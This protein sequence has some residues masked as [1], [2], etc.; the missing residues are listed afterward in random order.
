MPKAA[1]R[2][3][4]RRLADLEQHLRRLPEDPDVA[5]NGLVLAGVQ[6]AVLSAGFPRSAVAGWLR[7]IADVVEAEGPYLPIIGWI[8]DRED[9]DDRNT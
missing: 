3:D 5:A 1:S 9:A 2:V 7:M 4:R 8:A 6:A